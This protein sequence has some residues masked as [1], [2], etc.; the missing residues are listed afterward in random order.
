M[1]KIIDHKDFNPESLRQLAKY[2][3][4]S[5]EER[6][7]SIIN[8]VRKNK[9]QALFRYALGFDKTD[10]TRFGL[11]EKKSNFEKAYKKYLKNDPFFIE[12]LKKSIDRIKKF[13]NSQK[14]CGFLLRDD[15]DGIEI[16]GQIV[17]PIENVGIYIPGGK[18]LYPSTIIM[19]VIPARI[20]G[21]KNIYITTPVINNKPVPDEILATLHLLNIRHLFKIGGAHAI[22]AFAY[23]TQSIPRVD[24]IC[25]PGN[26]YVT[27]AK[28]LVFGD[29]DIDMIAGPTEV[30]IIADETSNPEHIALDLLS[31]AE[32]DEMATSIL[33][34]P[35]KSLAGKVRKS[36]NTLLNK[37][38]NPIAMESIKT[39]GKAVIV[40]SLH[41][42]FKISNTIAP[43]HLEIMLDSPFKYLPLVK[44]AG[45]IFLGSYSPESA[46][47]YIAG[48]NHTLPTMGSAR[49]YSQL[50]V[51]HFIKRIGIV[52]LSK[53]KLAHLQPFISKM[54]QKEKLLFHS[55]SAKRK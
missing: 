36:L 1:L 30:V 20:A 38:K 26:I 4:T 27:M 31:Q 37:Y 24:K 15:A 7:S 9:D 41:K 16:T 47:D 44:N 35:S 55:L 25:G 48:P 12:S 33:I 32:H 28:K 3:M 11:K 8:D 45:C 29:V 10:L 51:Y 21:V 13:H 53:E 14:E 5:I 49:F 6:V 52:H 54:A 23:G 17:T 39:H 22:A 42:A 19:N 46:G 43:E 2:D 50:G 18:A 40:D 34:T